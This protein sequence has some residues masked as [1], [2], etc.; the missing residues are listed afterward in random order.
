MRQKAGVRRA[1][2]ALIVVLAVLL[3]GAT[4]AA[5][6]HQ[7]LESAGWVSSLEVTGADGRPLAGAVTR[8]EATI[9]VRARPAC[10]G[11]KICG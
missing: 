11:I 8:K 7:P 6:H 10:L 5:L 9:K 2:L 4:V 1:L 3:A